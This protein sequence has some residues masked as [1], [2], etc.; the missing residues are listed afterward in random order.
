MFQ[1]VSQNFLIVLVFCFL[2]VSGAENKQVV[3][4]MLVSDNDSVYRY[5]YIYN[6]DG[7]P[8]VETKAL[9]Y[10]SEWQ[11]IS[12][13]EWFIQSNLPTAQTQRLWH[14]NKW[15][16]VQSVRYEMAGSKLVEIQATF[17]NNLQTDVRKIET[18]FT[19]NL[20]TAET[21]YTII[22]GSWVKTIQTRFFYNP[23][24]Q[25]DS[26]L[27]SH[28]DA[29]VLKTTYKTIYEYF[30]NGNCKTVIVSVK[31]DFDLMFVNVSR[32]S[33]SYKS[34]TNLLA[35]IR[36]QRWDSKISK[37]EYDTKSEYVY[38]EI[39]KILEEIAWEWNSQFWNQVLRYEYRY[40]AQNEIVSKLV[41]MP[42]FKDWRNTNSVNYLHESGSRNL[43]IESVYGFWGGK[44]GEKLNTYIA[45]PFNDETII[46]KAETIKL[47]YIPFFATSI[48]E[49]S[50]SKSIIQ[51]YPNPSKG[52]F[53]MSNFDAQKQ[54][55]TLCSLSGSALKQS[56]NKPCSSIVDITDFPNGIYVLR[57]NSD[58]FTHAQKIVKY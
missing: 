21:D 13:T 6:K 3:S 46:R 22:N 39:G 30:A 52:V 19:N 29:S 25:I 26:T 54:S 43:T 57:I 4:E 51:L 48:P 42:I 14:N 34:G 50:Q 1:S 9:K 55:W 41:S 38:D 49:T 10:G 32:T 31:N 8:V 20:K 7:Q 45:F 53:Y 33:Y 16:D 24:N 58:T 11:N 27:I 18:E 17:Q 23:S 15:N 35:E 40:N 5:A 44:S 2:H 56:G 47:T 36:N 12:Q 37:W 28:Y